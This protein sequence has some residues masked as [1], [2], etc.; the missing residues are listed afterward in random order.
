MGHPANEESSQ[1]CG[2]FL[3][4]LGQGSLLLTGQQGVANILENAYDGEKPTSLGM[5]NMWM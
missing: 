1:P 5:T 4:R 2:F 3:Y